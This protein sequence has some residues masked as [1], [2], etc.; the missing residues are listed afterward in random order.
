MLLSEQHV[1][2]DAERFISLNDA[3]GAKWYYGGQTEADDAVILLAEDDRKPVG[4]AYIQFEAINYAD[5]LQSA[6]W[7]HDIYIDEAAR[8]SGTG[9]ELIEASV[10]AAKRLG[11]DKLMLHVAAKNAIGTEFF[12]RNGFRTTML[13]MM[14][15]VAE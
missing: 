11:A 15:K 14:L 4:F 13:E 8:G 3:E 7:L 10:A 6:A 1:D 12:E 2:Y 9:Q 5:L